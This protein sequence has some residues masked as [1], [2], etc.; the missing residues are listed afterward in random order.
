[1]PPHIAIAVT[2]DIATDN[3]I[4][5]IATT[6]SEM[7]FKVTIAG[8]RLKRPVETTI[9]FQHKLFKLWFNKGPFFYAEM[10]LRLFFWVLTHRFKYV[11]ANDTD[12]LWGLTLA[13]SL[14]RT[15]L[16]FDA[17]EYF[18]QVPELVGRPKTQAVWQYIENRCIPK[19]EQCYTVCQS[20]AD[21]YHQ[22]YQKPFAVVRN[23]PFA[24]PKPAER[25]YCRKR[26]VLY[27]GALN[28]GRGIE[29]M[30]ESMKFVPNAE[31]W[32]A[33]SGDIEDNLKQLTL[34]LQLQ[35]KVVFWGRLPYA[36]LVPITQQARIGLSLEEDLGLNYHYAL[37]NKLFDYIQAR[38][39]VIV[40]NL[41]EMQKIVTDY[42]V[43]RVLSDPQAVVLAG[44]INAMLDMSVDQAEALVENLEKAAQ[45]LCW[46]NE[47]TKL[48]AIY[49]PYFQ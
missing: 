7:G 20:I 36:Q 14:K 16:F 49:K 3:R 39:P 15:K 9:S 40:A 30:I 35:T 23:V 47:K 45:E 37:P 31:L 32:I 12:T 24:L 41:P 22:T 33:G 29:L 21:I 44:M 42:K 6:L 18:T 11:L 46:E 19:A 34:T 5:R 2:N 17:H 48:E 27:Q 13:A 10:N 4:K 43:G 28:V 1:M 26:V 25:F 38:M 8:R